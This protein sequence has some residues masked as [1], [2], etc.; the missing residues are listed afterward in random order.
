MRIVDEIWQKLGFVNFQGQNALEIYDLTGDKYGFAECI[1][2]SFCSLNLINSSSLR[3]LIFAIVIFSGV[4]PES[5]SGSPAFA[6]SLPS[7]S[8]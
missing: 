8:L 5:G 6:S 2:I 7:A 1:D 3:R 4:I